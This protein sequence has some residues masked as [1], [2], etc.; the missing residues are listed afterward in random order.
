MQKEIT[1][2]LLETP[3]AKPDKVRTDVICEYAV[4]KNI[5][6]GLWLLQSCVQ[7]HLCKDS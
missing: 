5:D 3:G 2:K 4:I 1:K 7:P 6:P